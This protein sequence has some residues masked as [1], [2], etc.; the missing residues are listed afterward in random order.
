MHLHPRVRNMVDTTK[1]FSNQHGTVL[2]DPLRRVATC[3]VGPQGVQLPFCQRL[4]RPL[5][6][7]DAPVGCRVLIAAP[8]LAAEPL[9]EPKGHRT[10]KAPMRRPR[11]FC[12]TGC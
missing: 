11:D 2:E 10:A 7:A 9:S 4:A 5:V 8:R 12:L 1:E 6:V 3:Q